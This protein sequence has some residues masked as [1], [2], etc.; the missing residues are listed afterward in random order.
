[1]A[2]SPSLLV[3]D[4][5]WSFWRG[6]GVLRELDSGWVWLGML[7]EGTTDAGKACGAA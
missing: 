5:P 3:G 4:K 1:M 2:V 6:G 7:W